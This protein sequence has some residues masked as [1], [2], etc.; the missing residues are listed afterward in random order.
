MASQPIQIKTPVYEYKK[1]FTQA[2]D[3]RDI[4]PTFF[5]D[6]SLRQRANALFCRAI[7][8]GSLASGSSS[9]I[10]DVSVSPSESEKAREYTGESSTKESVWENV[11]IENVPKARSP[12]VIGVKKK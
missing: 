6:R 4:T 12:V 2:S 1:D 10:C 8:P 7:L 5:E 9:G 11:R 3:S